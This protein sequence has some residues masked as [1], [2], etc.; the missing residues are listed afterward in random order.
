MGLQRKHPGQGVM[1]RDGSLLLCMQFRI[2]LAE[3]IVD[4]FAV[5]FSTAAM[6]KLGLSQAMISTS[7]HPR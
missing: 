6:V 3:E 7:N 1:F 4:D 2:A 5:I